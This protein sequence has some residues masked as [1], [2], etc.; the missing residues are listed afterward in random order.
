MRETTY[1]AMDVKTVA[2]GDALAVPQFVESNF[3]PLVTPEGQQ[4]AQVPVAVHRFPL[5]RED[6][7]KLIKELQEIV[8][9]MP[10][11]KKKSDLIIAGDSTQAEKMAEMNQNIRAGT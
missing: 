2:E 6:A 8:D 10:E 7:E 1:Q 5:Q 11:P 3:I 4:V 9:A